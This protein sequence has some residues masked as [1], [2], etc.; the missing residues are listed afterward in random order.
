MGHETS[1]D[2]DAALDA[3][4]SAIACE[5]SVPFDRVATG[6]KRCSHQTAEQQW[7]IML[8]EEE[9]AATKPN[10]ATMM[11]HPADSPRC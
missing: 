5:L 7:Q 11:A 4:L 1:V 2:K 6:W 3:D 10:S 9:K 8:C